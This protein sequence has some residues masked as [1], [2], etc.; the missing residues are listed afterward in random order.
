MPP[1][2][3]RRTLGL[4]TGIAIV[5]GTIIGGGI[6]LVPSAMVRAVG[7]PAEV[8]VVWIFGGV[9]TLFGAL[10]YAELAAAIPDAGGTYTYLRVAYGPFFGFLY[11]WS[12]SV[13]VRPASYAAFGAGFY[14]YLSDFFP[15]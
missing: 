1:N 14:R 5:V 11:G 8:F 7:S 13:I 6:F 10:T 12:E 2:E 15:G 3:L 4:W 9:L